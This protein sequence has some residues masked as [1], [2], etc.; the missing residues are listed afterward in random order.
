[1]AW[2][3]SVVRRCRK[4]HS[5]GVIFKAPDLYRISSRRS[6]A[7]P[8]RAG[9]QVLGQSLDNV[10]GL[11]ITAVMELPLAHRDDRVGVRQ[12]TRLLGGREQVR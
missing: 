8:A 9:R 6:S 1:M 10:E 2:V 3:C 7:W 5:L 4:S 12:Q 11:L